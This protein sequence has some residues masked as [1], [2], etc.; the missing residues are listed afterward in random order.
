MKA[1]L[2]SFFTVLGRVGPVKSF[3]P[4]LLVVV[5]FAGNGKLRRCATWVK[6]YLLVLL[7]AFAKEVVAWVDGSLESFAQADYEMVIEVLCVAD[8][9]RPVLGLAPRGQDGRVD[10]PQEV[11]ERARERDAEGGR[12]ANRK[13]PR[14]PPRR[15]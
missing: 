3:I 4:D 15:D 1:W 10:L 2:P 5:A 12:F 9:R 11:I 8:V 6:Q 14:A 13:V 7:V